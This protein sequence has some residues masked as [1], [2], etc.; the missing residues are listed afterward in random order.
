MMYNTDFCLNVHNNQTY[1]IGSGNRPGACMV[2][3]KINER[4]I[5]FSHIKS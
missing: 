4:I 2:L 5:S 3:Q 1:K